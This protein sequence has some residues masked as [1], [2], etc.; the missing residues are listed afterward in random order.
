MMIQVEEAWYGVVWSGL[1][2]APLE[3]A[4]RKPLPRR[5]GNIHLLAEQKPAWVQS[6]HS[7]PGRA[8]AG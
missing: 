5:R 8:E 4:L 3:L 7:C 6:P 1:L 2:Q